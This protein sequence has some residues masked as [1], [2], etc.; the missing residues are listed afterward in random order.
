MDPSFV[1]NHLINLLLVV[2]ALHLLP[3]IVEQ[4]FSVI[5]RILEEYERFLRWYRD[6][7]AE[8]WPRAKSS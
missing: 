7:K 6:W 2:G 4:S 3:T 1:K 5:Q 8:L